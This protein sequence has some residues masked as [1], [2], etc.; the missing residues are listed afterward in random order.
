MLLA[1][2]ATARGSLSD[3]RAVSVAEV[4]SVCFYDDDHDD[5]GDILLLRT[6]NISWASW[7]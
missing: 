7:P 2:A 6:R 5:H 1:R 3:R 4:I